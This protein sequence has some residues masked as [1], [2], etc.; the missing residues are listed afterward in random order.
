MRNMISIGF[1]ENTLTLLIFPLENYFFYEIYYF[2]S[3]NQIF[4]GKYPTCQVRHT[5]IF[6][7]KVVIFSLDKGVSLIFMTFNETSSYAGAK[8]LPWQMAKFFRH[9]VNYVIS[10]LNKDVLVKYYIKT[11]VCF[12]L[13]F[14]ILIY[15]NVTFEDKYKNLII[16]FV[17]YTVIIATYFLHLK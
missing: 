3:E 14:C 13:I 1:V 4:K 10:E 15:S 6:N 8:I 12:F 11:S 17:R 7:T 9:S 2:L 5:K 16:I